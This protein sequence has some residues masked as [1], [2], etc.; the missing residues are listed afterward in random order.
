[1]LSVPR[2]PWAEP[3][4]LKSRFLEES[5][6]RHPDAGGS[7]E[8]F[9]SLNAAWQ[10]LRHPASLLRHFLELEHPEAL[11]KTPR[12]PADLGDLFM[13]IAAARQAAQQFGVQWAA[14]TSPLARSLLEAGR[15]GLVTRFGGLSTQ[16]ATRLDA[17]LAPLIAGE[18]DPAK[19]TELLARL[20]FLGKWA[21]QLREA[22]LTLG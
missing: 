11:A 20:V 16:V 1:M 18:R 4:L 14:A 8:A 10:T 12:T 5:A 13:D 19:L 21:D 7:A 9:T 17:A 3:D 2:A 15:R 6:S 22:S